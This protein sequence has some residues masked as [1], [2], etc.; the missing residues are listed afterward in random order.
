MGRNVEL[1]QGWAKSRNSEP[2]TRE[3]KRQGLVCDPVPEYC[4]RVL[5]HAC[6][7]T[8][9]RPTDQRGAMKPSWQTQ[10]MVDFTVTSA[11]GVVTSYSGA[12]AR[13]DLNARSGV[14]V[15]FDGKGKRLKYSPSGWLCVEDRDKVSAHGPGVETG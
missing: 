14:L 9:A 3:G 8:G 15:L 6:F 5:H 7:R 4:D 10:R 13:H 12:E 11:D 2:A 1:A